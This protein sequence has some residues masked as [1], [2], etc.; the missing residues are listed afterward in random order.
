MA[1]TI[2]SFSL[3]IAMLIGTIAYPVTA[4]TT[5]QNSGI[6][7]FISIFRRRRPQ[8][9]GTSR[10]EGR[11]CLLSPGI[12]ETQAI[13]WSDRPLFLWRNDVREIQLLDFKTQQPIWTP[14]LAQSNQTDINMLQVDTSLQPGATYTWIFSDGASSGSKVFQI[15]PDEQRYPIQQELQHLEQRLQ[16]RGETPEAIAIAKANYF[17]QK[18][19]WS[20]ALQV[21][22]GV[23]NPSVAV[24]RVQQQMIPRLCNQER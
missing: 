4:Q 3:M 14:T 9:L 24:L 2:L 17:S 11:A 16:A 19:L 23:E 8:W 7:E 20:D 15:M 13:I 21:L 1:R 6:E 12:L 5:A 18:D 22:Y 10:G